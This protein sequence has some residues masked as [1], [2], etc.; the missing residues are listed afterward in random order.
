[1]STLPADR[2]ACP[3][4]GSESRDELAYVPGRNGPV[5]C[6][7]YDWHDEDARSP[8]DLSPEDVIRAA[9]DLRA[10]NS[11]LAELAGLIHDAQCTRVRPCGYGRP[12][13]PHDGYYRELAGTVYG[14][15]EPEIGAENVLIATRVILGEL[16]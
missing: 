16:W 10:R 15:L 11:Y 7:D 5:S 3:S 12:G 8:G 4:C 14:R 1:M 6:S 2:K 9:D 13:D